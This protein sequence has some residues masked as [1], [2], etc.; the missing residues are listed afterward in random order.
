MLQKTPFPHTAPLPPDV[1][2]VLDA[3]YAKFDP[4]K[5]PPVPC[6]RCPDYVPEGG[7]WKL[8]FN[9]GVYRIFHD[10]TGWRSIGSFVVDGN[11]VR[12]F[13][14]PTCMEVTGAYIWKLKDGRLILQVIED[15]CAI[16]MRAKNLTMLPWMSC[17]PPSMEAG[18]SGH[19]NAPP[20]CD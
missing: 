18:Y 13:N 3:T 9:S 6:R 5:K 17:Q 16:G 10:F 2:T 20:G 12:L 1:P 11:R 19:W 7:I 8:N 4:K 15:D 14:D